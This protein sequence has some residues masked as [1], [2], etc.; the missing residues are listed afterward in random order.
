MVQSINLHT[1]P[2]LV[3]PTAPAQVTANAPEP[4]KVSAPALLRVDV[5]LA[6]A[7]SEPPP[8]YSKPHNYADFLLATEKQGNIASAISQQLSA[9]V[10]PSQVANFSPSQYLNRVGTLSAETSLYR[11]EARHM[12][13][14][15]G[16]SVEKFRPDF[17]APIGQLK[18]SLTLT[19]RTKEGDEINVVMAH[20]KDANS[21][22]VEFS[23]KV[24]GKLSEAEQQA[25]DVL[26]KKMGQLGDEFFSTG[27]LSLRGL[28]DIDTNALTEFHIDFGKDNGGKWVDANYDFAFNPETFEQ[29]LSGT[30]TNGFNFII[31][32]KMKNLL[33]QLAHGN[34]AQ[35]Q[36]YLDKMEQSTNPMDMPS[37]SQLF[38]R[39]ALF[40]AL[41][42]NVAPDQKT[43]I[44]TESDKPPAELFSMFDSGLP[45]FSANF[46]APNNYKLYRALP[47]SMSLH[48]EQTTRAEKQSVVDGD[49]IK[50][51]WELHQQANV[52][53][54]S[55]QVDA[56]SEEEFD[57]GNY[58][59]KEAH[60][61]LKNDR[62]MRI[63]DG[64]LDDVIEAKNGVDNSTEKVYSNSVLLYQK[65]SENP[66][67]QFRRLSELENMTVLNKSAA[68]RQ[69]AVSS[70]MSGKLF[71]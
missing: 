15:S 4:L 21:D 9:S 41:G 67:E 7:A 35:L 49:Q 31:D 40:S 13:L 39:D 52:E 20:R 55:R 48:M 64:V 69:T 54:N 18:Q 61:S 66:R 11:N 26:A 27:N 44:D 24:K 28:T 36:Q 51:V 68:K 32:A 43:P 16:A 57:K 8:V 33:G 3:L 60:Q 53:F 34:T 23:F 56:A 62:H 10:Q 6:V 17:T 71:F 42:V 30:D 22:S 38:F 63:V 46:H 25:I 5:S 37:S 50:I 70:F 1:F 29:S 45:D 2:P 59:V 12:P 47:L 14:P 19:I 65:A 58:S